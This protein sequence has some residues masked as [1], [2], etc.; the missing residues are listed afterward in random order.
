MESA[1]YLSGLLA[2]GF[3]R[4]LQ[5]KIAALGISPGQ[6]PILVTL[7]NEDGITQRELVERLEIEQA[8][9]ANTLSRM[10]RDDLV[11]RRAHPKDKR[12]Q[13]LYLTDRAKSLKDAALKA[14][15]E[16]D[17]ALFSGFRRFERELLMEYMRWAVENARKL[18]DGVDPAEAQIHDL[19]PIPV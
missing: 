2:K 1:V 14:A 16:A 11:E 13:L 8:T 15:E 17:E 4:S 7:W 3:S 6:Y 10:V 19:R 5:H 9:I 18:E 12:A